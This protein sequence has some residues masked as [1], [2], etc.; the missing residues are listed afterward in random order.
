MGS[1]QVRRRCDGK[2]LVSAKPLIPPISLQAKPH[3]A[4]FDPQLFRT[5]QLRHTYV[6]EIPRQN[7]RL[8][9][10]RTIL[11]DARVTWLITTLLLHNNG[12]SLGAAARI[13]DSG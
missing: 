8:R 4:R 12:W 1:Y 13:G 5:P 6:G 11:S 2:L 10:Q 3:D 7:M 9:N